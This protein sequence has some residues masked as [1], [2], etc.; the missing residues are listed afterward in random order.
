M[1]QNRS[2][3]IFLG[4]VTSDSD[5]HFT[6]AS[7]HISYTTINVF[8]QLRPSPVAAVSHVSTAMIYIV[9]YMRTRATP[10]R[11]GQINMYPAARARMLSMKRDLRHDVAFSDSLRL[12]SK[13]PLCVGP[14]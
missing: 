3:H 10:G 8:I 4:P 11:A 13:L 2:T 12:A 9:L 1:A 6:L 7:S 14:R 5:R